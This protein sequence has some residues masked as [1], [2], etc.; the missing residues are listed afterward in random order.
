MNLNLALCY[1]KLNRNLDARNE[2]NSVL[3]VDAN[4]EKALFR[5]G[6]VRINESYHIQL[7][8]R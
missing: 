1:L 5:R 7:S 6:Q 3:E 4:N 2:C 8:F